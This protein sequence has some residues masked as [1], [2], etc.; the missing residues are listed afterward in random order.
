MQPSIIFIFRRAADPGGWL[1]GS[2]AIK[3]LSRIIADLILS[4]GVD[5]SKIDYTVLS[6]AIISTQT[7][8]DSIRLFIKCLS[9][10]DEKK[11]MEV[12]AEL[13]EPY[14]EIALYGK[15]PKLDNNK[16]NLEFVRLLKDNDFISSIK[17][18]K[19][20]IKVNTFRNSDH[21]EG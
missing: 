12:L 6:A 13:P 11:T 2:G 17:E 18:E 19:D 7:S 9:F 1:R 21:S 10:W 8:S 14:C 16:T 3:R 5:C 15:R 20:L 4:N